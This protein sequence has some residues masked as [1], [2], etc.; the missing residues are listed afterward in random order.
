MGA[1][2]YK[3]STFSDVVFSLWFGENSRARGNCGCDGYVNSRS[4]G[5]EFNFNLFS[6][7]SVCRSAFC[8]VSVCV[9]V[10]IIW[11]IVC[12][13]S[14]LLLFGFRFYDSFVLETIHFS[15][16]LPLSL[17][18]WIFLISISWSDGFITKI[19]CD[20]CCFFS[21]L[22]LQLKDITYIQSHFIRV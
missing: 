4:N 12:V 3:R 15:P 19:H 10:A 6:A 14:W 1:S 5:E 17:S 20:G 13:E 9:C 22:S 11:E 18:P 16:S 7:F 21:F 8:Q 2:G